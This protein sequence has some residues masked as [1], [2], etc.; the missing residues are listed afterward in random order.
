M[1][2]FN[3][4]TVGAIHLYILFS[5]TSKGPP[6]PFTTMWQI[7][8]LFENCLASDLSVCFFFFSCCVICLEHILLVWWATICVSSL[9]E[10]SILCPEWIIPTP[11]TLCRVLW[12]CQF[13]LW[14]SF[15]CTCLTC[16]TGCCFSAEQ[17]SN[18]LMCLWYPLLGLVHS[19]YI[20]NC[21][22][23]NEWMGVV[24]ISRNV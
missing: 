17:S 23:M 5:Y 2:P 10:E 11:L 12:L 15:A 24:N 9:I 7:T 3:A 16:Q 4:H 22:G 13:Q 20:I 1:A 18:S 8:H 6:S 14:S 19:R 21:T